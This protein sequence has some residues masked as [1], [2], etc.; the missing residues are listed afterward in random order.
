MSKFISFYAKL[1]VKGRI[2][3]AS[4]AFSIDRVSKQENTRNDNFS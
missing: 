4:E 3:I 2:R 1:K